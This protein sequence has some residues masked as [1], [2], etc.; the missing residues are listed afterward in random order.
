LAAHQA[1]R[2]KQK[3]RTKA[4]NI[5]AVKLAGIP[6]TLKATSH[7]SAKPPNKK[8]KVDISAA[9]LSA[10]LSTSLTVVPPMSA[11]NRNEST[12]LAIKDIVQLTRD[13]AKE[14]KAR[15]LKSSKG[16]KKS[17]SRKAGSSLQPPL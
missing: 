5:A 8:M 17:H 10:S 12:R 7:Q 3:T 9:P 6:E 16:I 14:V 4:P 13:R 2:V 15:S 1:K 11:S